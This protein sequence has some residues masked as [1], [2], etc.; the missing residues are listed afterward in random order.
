[1][2]NENFTKM[3]TVSKKYFELLGNK[4]DA[5]CYAMLR[6]V[7]KEFRLDASSPRLFAVARVSFSDYFTSL[8]WCILY[9]DFSK[10]YLSVYWHNRRWNIARIS[11]SLR[12][13]F[14]P[15]YV[16]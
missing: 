15:F 13:I 11:K 12:E 8:S 16:K 5:E 3:K 1:M 7:V 14:E 6:P 4:T 2:F 10:R 9:D